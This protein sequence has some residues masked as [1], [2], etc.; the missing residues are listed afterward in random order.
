[1]HIPDGFLSPAVAVTAWVLAG[2]G[3]ASAALAFAVVRKIRTVGDDA[4]R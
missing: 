3:I 4:H 1:M 2:T